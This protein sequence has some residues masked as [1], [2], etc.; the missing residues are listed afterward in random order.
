[1]T[2]K[3]NRRGRAGISGVV[4]ALILFVML[5]TVGTTYF[6]WVNQN[7]AVYDQALASRNNANLALESESLSLVATAPLGTLSLAA[8]NTGALPVNMTNVFVV[9]SSGNVVCQKVL[10]QVTTPCPPVPQTAPIGV[11][12]NP[13]ASQPTSVSTGQ[14]IS[15]G[16]TYT[17]KVLTQR[18]NV[19]SAAYMGIGVATTLSAT[20]IG[21][22]SSVTDT[23]AIS[24]GSNP[25]GSVSFF[26]STTNTC[27]TAAATQVGGTGTTFPVI[28]GSAT[29][30]SVAFNS[31]GQDYWYATYNG[32][33]NN[34][35][36]ENSL[37]EPLT[38]VTAQPTLTTSV[39]PPV[40][41]IGSSAL[42]TAYFSGGSPALAGTAS[43]SLYKGATCTGIL[44]FGPDLEPVAGNGAVPSK[45]FAPASVGTY[46]WQ[47]SFTAT[48][49][50]DKSIPAQ[51][52]GTGETLTVNAA[53]SSISTLLSDTTIT[54]GSSAYDTATLSSVTGNAAGTVQYSYFANGGCTGTATPVGGPVAVTNG[55]PLKSGSQTFA[56]FGSY[57]WNAAYSGDANNNPATSPCEPLTVQKV[58]S[59]ST[60]LLSPSIPVGGSVSDSATLF[61]ATSGA[62]GTISFWWSLVN[63]CPTNGA[64]LF[65]S[66][67]VSGN[68]IYP[69]VPSQPL[70][71]P[72]VYYVY[73]TYGGDA[74]DA[75][76]T[77]PCEPL[78]VG[79]AV[80]TQLSAGT[81]TVGGSV[82][83]S[84][85]L[86]FATSSAGGTVTYDWFSGS[87]C[88]GS[89]TQVGMPVTV[90]NGV[91]PPS[92]AVPFNNAGS[93]SWDAVYSGDANN[94]GPVT[95]PCEPLTVITSTGG[96]TGSLQQV[97]G[98]FKFYYTNCNPTGGTGNQCL[99]DGVNANGYY[100]YGVSFSG[101]CDSDDVQPSGACIQDNDDTTAPD[102]FQISLTNSDPS[103][104]SISLSSQSFIWLQGQCLA[105]GGN[106]CQNSNP[107]ACF[108][109]PGDC[110]TFSQ[111][112]WISDGLGCA[113]GCDGQ[114]VDAL[115][116][117]TPVVIAAGTT[118][119]LYFYC[120]GPCTSPGTPTG[121]TTNPAPQTYLTVSIALYGSYSDGTPFGQSIP[122]IASYVSPVGIVGC[123]I[124]S[125][126]CWA[127]TP[128][129]QINIAQGSSQTI[130]LSVQGFPAQPSNPFTISL[131]WATAVTPISTASCNYNSQPCSISFSVPSGT[132]PGYYPI[133]VTSDG[134]NNAYATVQVLGGTSTTITCTSTTLGLGQTTP[135]TA[136]VTGSSPT[137]TITWSQTGGSGSVSFT[138]STCTLSTGAC[139][140]SVKG[141][142]VGNPTIQASYSGDGSNAPS[143]GTITLTVGKSVT[144]TAVSCSGTTCTATV[145]GFSGTV[146]GETI[147]WSQSG[148]GSVTFSPGTTCALSAGGTCSIT[149]KGATAGAVTIQASYPGDANNLA[150]SGTASLT[151][152]TTT[153]TV[154][155][156]PASFAMGATTSCTATLTGFTAPVTGETIRMSQTGGTGTISFPSGTTCALSAG[157][158]CS[159]TVTGTGVGSPI[160]TASYGGD[161]INLASSGTATLTVTKA[162]TT[163]A[164]SC[165]PTSFGT[166]A[167]SSC[168]ATLTGF[169]GTV[170]GETITWSQTGGTGTVTFSGGGTCALSAGGTCSVT[171]TGTGVGSPIVTASYG[172]DA[173]NLASSGTATLTVTKATTT[174]AVSCVPTSFGTG[175]TSSCTATLTGFSGTVTGETI[176]WSQTGGTGTVTFSGG[177]TCALSA[178]G[179][180]SV[181][182]TGATRGTATIKASYSGDTNNAASS[183]TA[184]LTVEAV[185]STAVSCVPV[186][187]AAGT[188]TSCTATLTGFTAPVTGETIT[189]SQ[190]GGTGTISF[191]SGTTCALS[192][193]GTCSVTVNG[194]T[195]G[196]VT[197]TASYPGDANNLA[198]TGNT[199]IT[200]TKATTA[201][202]VSCVPNSFGV[203]ATSS[204]TA[205]VTGFSG[206]VT[207]ETITM[208]KTGGT[209]SVTFPSGT[210]CA[211]SAGGT[212]SVTVNGATTGPVTIQASYP[213]D[214][215]NLAS[216]G[217][218][219]I[220]IVNKV[221]S[222]TT[223]ACV[224]TKFANGRTTTCTATVTGQSPTGTITWS[225]SGG[226]GSVSFS[227][228]T[229]TLSG[230]SCSTT[231]TGTGVGSPTIL[232]SYGGDS[233]NL[234]STGTLSV[235]V[236]IAMNLVWQ[237]HQDC[238]GANSCQ[239]SLEPT[240]SG[241]LLVVTISYYDTGSARTI[242]SVSDGHNTYTQAVTSN[243]VGG[244]LVSAVYY[245]VATFTGNARVTV[246]LSGSPNT[247]FQ[248]VFAEFSGTYLSGSVLGPTATGSCSSGGSCS[249]SLVTSSAV[250]YGT[251]SVLIG[252]STTHGGNS[253]SG[254]GAF[255]EF[256]GSC[257]STNDGC[258][259]Y[260]LPTSAGSTNFPASSAGGDDWADVGVVFVDPPAPLS[261]TSSLSGGTSQA[262]LGGIGLSLYIPVIGIQAQLT[263]LVSMWS[264]AG[265]K[266]NQC[267]RRVWS[268][269][270]N[271]F[272][273]LLK[274]GGFP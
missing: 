195:A 131:Y 244:R 96:Q 119:T 122:F 259:E 201:T 23:A 192:A 46:T 186:S 249:P 70:S 187:F 258:G 205:T 231:V 146:T 214:A 22:G 98:S 97:V 124:A 123:T 263:A 241:Y 41:N 66:V 158:T 108:L 242:S 133:Y 9:D 75:G 31:A 211:L 209:G 163:T 52:G 155:C 271:T 228:T 218:T 72:G 43:F 62:G 222:T 204:C 147:T 137:G 135:C 239:S 130:A 161:E 25:Q 64:T 88:A 265:I 167:T 166:G 113:S 160:V 4:G 91:V 59:V 149:V 238:T 136:T 67:P 138:P 18:G 92:T 125:V 219:N 191:P 15:P 118:A 101:T 116:Y 93:Y 83:D 154:A 127:G 252:A 197:I 42:D 5:F 151:I 13:G 129:P 56:T 141:T 268:L 208:S 236:G 203:G 266:M 63:A 200:V 36:G 180:C 90:S 57:S 14:A 196:P 206:T 115:P 49:A 120:A 156:V 170:T 20:T 175:A 172:G 269:D 174:T 100:A 112:Y 253:I 114:G 85:T 1:M 251:S 183:G 55:V 12:I 233:A 159:V 110:L 248:I 33:S 234:A 185:T 267:F 237:N 54:V 165:V 194:A 162:T 254:G 256:S 89:P 102:M 264:Y 245:S 77:S 61:G 210:T 193:G 105:Q 3:P 10:K 17:I 229:C 11:V 221:A 6:L 255:N 139:T 270:F 273:S 178:G 207:G 212:C 140:V 224:P 74:N 82:S 215:N 27:P 21:A 188:I 134:V 73:A 213:T 107:F 220:T 199:G 106:G 226:T 190:T 216:S 169:S 2:L 28:G 173:A 79:L 8:Q 145:A 235:T 94:Q 144:A 176:T 84:S 104:R 243:A 257:S 44:V 48:D 71:T 260:E 24:G 261:P 69:S 53:T 126:S 230:G 246:A 32:D 164:V 103:G 179:T 19:F 37:C 80:T 181:T 202:A 51:C 250:S 39:S 95:S 171:V 35:G 58:P 78:T 132:G 157:G 184:S 86:H 272:S 40:I 121:P 87:S 60:T 240:T 198:S 81:I 217:T 34:P 182:V 109:S 232:A 7:N 30:S 247:A 128:P 142:G 38:V 150:S 65:S 152:H 68:G 29:S 225:Q 143:T 223:V 177:G 76:V 16:A 47:V 153:T 148:A 50:N 227:P 168:T 262:N 117:T 26:Y 111:G 189:M 45:Q 274:R 99:G